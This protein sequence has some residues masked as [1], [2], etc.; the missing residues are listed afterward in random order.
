MAAEAG[1]PPS[2]LDVKRLQRKLI[3]VGNLP[4]AV[5]EAKDSF[6]LSDEAIAAAV[7]RLANGYDG[8]AEIFSD[9]A[10]ALPALYR[11]G[12]PDGSAERSLRSYLADPRRVYA[13]FARKVLA[14]RP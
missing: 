9:P 12:D 5:L 3:A 8:L 7:K 14:A 13:N 4:P 11:I 1:V 6:P 10:R 2:A